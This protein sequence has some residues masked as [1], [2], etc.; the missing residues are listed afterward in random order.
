MNV[1]QSPATLESVLPAQP[2]AAAGSS[3]TAF[4]LVAIAATA[5]VAPMWFIGNASGHDIQ[6][7]LASWMDVANQWRE[8]IIYPRWA[9]WA[10]WGCG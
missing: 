8:G 9:E 7:H 10:N 1:I 4:L 2:R 6:F 3:R 5:V